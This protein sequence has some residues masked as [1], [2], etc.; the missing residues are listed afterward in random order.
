MKRV[1]WT[2][3]LINAMAVLLIV[4]LWT[5]STADDHLKFLQREAILFFPLV[6]VAVSLVDIGPLNRVRAFFFLGVAMIMGVG[7]GNFTGWALVYVLCVLGLWIG[8]YQERESTKSEEQKQAERW[9]REYGGP[10]TW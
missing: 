1:Q 10:T 5:A 4:I 3:A 6:A 7:L 9:D 2:T 8:G